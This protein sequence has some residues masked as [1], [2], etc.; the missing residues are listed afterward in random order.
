[1]DVQTHVDRLQA[2]ADQI[3]SY[4]DN[5]SLSAVVVAGSGLSDMIDSYDVIKRMPYNEITN[6]PSSEVQGHGKEVV[7]A[8]HRDHLVLFFTGRFHYYQG[9]DPILTATPAWI[10]AFL[11]SPRYIITNAAGGLHKDFSIGDLVLIK[12]HIN[13]TGT[14]PLR[15]V[16]IPGFEN[17]FFDTSELYN[18]DALCAL[19]EVARTQDQTLNQG[20]YAYFLGPNFETPAEINMLRVVGADLVGMSSV[21]EALVA[22]RFGIKTTGLSVVT[23]TYPFPGQKV[24][25]VTHDEVLQATQNA[26]GRLSTLVQGWID[27][28]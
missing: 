12:D 22:H 2:C 20:V 24:T 10:A 5:P 15:G 9:M 11:N 18:P 19:R 23:N 3:A 13:M 17:P 6:M 14:N 26:K 7:L 27:T 8:K 25:R 4:F 28:W 16:S 1:M 21:P